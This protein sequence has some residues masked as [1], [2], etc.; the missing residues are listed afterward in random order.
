MYG[1]EGRSCARVPYDVVIALFRR[2]ETRP[3]VAVKRC[4]AAPAGNRVR[5]RD[6]ARVGN[7]R[8]IAVHDDASTD[9]RSILKGSILLKKRQANRLPF[10]SARIIAIGSRS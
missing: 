9:P 1:E 6:A 3:V 5:K 7:E 4:F 8:T 10:R 2:M